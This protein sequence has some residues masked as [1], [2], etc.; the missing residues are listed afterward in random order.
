MKNITVIGSGT[1]GNGIAHTFA[2]HGF[3]VSMV[4]INADALAKGL[5]TIEK[6]LDRQLSKG[7]IDEQS[8]QTTLHN[9]TTY[10]E[11]EA[12]VKYADLVIEAATENI[13]LKLKIF[14]QLDELCPAGTI[15]A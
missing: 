7:V 10:T 15:L 8:K 13:D 1:M 3:K 12:A 2:Q 11:T 9:I 14:K 5:Q 4:D 6:N